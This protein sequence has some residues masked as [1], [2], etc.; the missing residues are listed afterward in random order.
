ATTV[1]AGLQTFHRT[2]GTWHKAVDKFVTCSSFAREKFLSIGLPAEKV[3]V[4]PNFVNPDSGTG[5][6]LG[7]YAVFV[8]RLS[9][10][11]G[12]ETVLS[13][14]R[15][16]SEPIRLKIVGDGPLAN[17]VRAAAEKDSRIEWM[18]WRK[19]D[20]VLGIVGNASVLLMPSLWYEIFG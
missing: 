10:E 14:W 2:I 16:M 19:L 4:K 9:P 15:R 13:A 7:G 5:N 20:E 6:G 11:K 3:V 17:L 18:G 8:G 1:V 12:I